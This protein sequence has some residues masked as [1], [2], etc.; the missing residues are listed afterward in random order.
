MPLV[1]WTDAMSVGVATFDEEHHAIISF[2]NELYDSL[3]NGVDEKVCLQ[4][5]FDLVPVFTDHLEHEDR[6][7]EVTEYPGYRAHL[8]KHNEA[9]LYLIDLKS[10]VDSGVEAGAGKD[11]LNF[12][13]AWL[14][15]HLFHYDRGYRRHLNAR[16]IV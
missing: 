13:T 3:E 9:R 7:M 15:D 5:F 8:A 11:A 2:L 4:R 6:M 1:E 10:R 14:I 16:G 12:M